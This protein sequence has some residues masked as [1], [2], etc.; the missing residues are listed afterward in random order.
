MFLKNICH[1][2]LPTMEKLM[3]LSSARHAEGLKRA[4]TVLQQGLITLDEYYQVKE[5]LLSGLTGFK[6]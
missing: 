3:T 1:I 2:I 6:V 4:W 5:N